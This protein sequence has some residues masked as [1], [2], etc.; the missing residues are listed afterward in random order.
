MTGAN[1]GAICCLEEMLGRPMQRAVCLLHCNEL[2][3][4]HVFLELDGST[5]G[6][7]A[8]SGPIRKKLV[9]PVSSW[10]VKKFQPILNSTFPE[11]PNYL[12]EDLSFDQHYSY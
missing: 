12:L 7:N 4:R 3:L 1:R 10:E 9:G 2:P 11:L 6:P 8:F 5:A